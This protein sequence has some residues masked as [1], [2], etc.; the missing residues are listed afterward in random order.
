MRTREIDL[1]D[2]AEM[3]RFHEIGWRAEMEDGRPWNTFQSFDEWAAAVREPSP[4]QRVDTI[5]IFDGD[6]MVGGGIVWLSL[7]DNVEKAY[8]F[9]CRRARAAP[10]GHRRAADGG[11][12][13]ARP[14]AGPHRADERHVL[15]LRRAGDVAGARFVA[16][17]GFT[18]ANVEVIR[19]LALPVADALLDEIDAEVARAPR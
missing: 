2:D 9:P 15:P 10:A 1:R 8:V 13:R 16:A 14:R 5:G 19:M 17:H 12:R 6:R 7:D 11:A 3:R 4:G 18:P